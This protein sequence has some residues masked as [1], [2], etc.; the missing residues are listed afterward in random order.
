LK[1]FPNL[2]QQETSLPVRLAPD[3]LVCVALGAGKF[4]ET[5]EDIRKAQRKY[6]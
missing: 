2:I 1:G 6:E 3:P 5:L 4:L